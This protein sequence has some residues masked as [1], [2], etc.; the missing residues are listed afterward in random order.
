MYIFNKKTSNLKLQQNN[1]FEADKN[2]ED[3][4]IALF[5]ANAD[6][7]LD[8][9]IA[10][11]GYHNFAVHDPLLQDRLYLNDGKGNFTKD[12]DALPAILESSSTVAVNDFNKDG[13]P[14]IFVGARV[15]PGRYPET[16]KN[17]LLINDGKGQFSNQI[18]TIVPDLE[19]IGMVTDAIWI[20]INRDQQK[21]LVVV[22]E[23]MPIS[24][25]ISK[26]EQLINQT[27]DYFKGAY[28]GWWNTIAV[29]DFNKDQQPDLLVGNV[30]TNTPFQ[31]S[32]AE[33]GEIYFKDFD[34]NGSVDPF[35]SSYTQG[36]SYPYVTRDELLGQL[37]HLRS[38]YTSY[39]SYA[40]AQL[41]D[42]FAKG[43]LKDAG[44]LQVQEMETSLFLSTANGSYQKATLPIEVQYAPINATSILDFDKD[45]VE[46]VVLCGNNSHTRLRMG[47]LDANYGM[48]LKGDGQGT[49]QYINQAAS[50]LDIRGDVQAVLAIDNILYFGINQGDL[51]AYEIQ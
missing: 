41:T 30:G 13:H 25:F 8:L 39:E 29:G 42:I 31:I 6:G 10:S 20:D 15:I 46:D 16:P 18:K 28:N 45:G 14:D 1:I 7:H 33:P 35:F 44:H 2:K 51:V 32:E 26:E 17:Y 43:E 4:A 49:F 37:S 23:W 22:G 21:D 40:D 47:K 12:S 3:A 5:D 48:L 38:K 24:I 27:S 34:Q 36:K 9:Y 11:G 50:G 19:T